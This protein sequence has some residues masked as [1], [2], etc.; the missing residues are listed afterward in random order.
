MK[1]LLFDIENSPIVTWSWGIHADPSH[2][3]K[4]VKENWYVMCWSAKWLNS[5]EVIS[6]AL[7]D[8]QY[9]HKKPC[10][11][12][13][14]KDLWKLLDEADIVIAHNGKRFDCKKSNARFMMHGMTPPSPYKVID[15]LTVSRSMFMFT[16]NRL[17]DLGQYLGVG[18][19]IDTGGFDLWKEC[20]E[21]NLKSWDKMIKYCKQDVILLEKVY[22]KI[23]PYIKNHP[24]L[25]LDNGNCPKC[26]SSKLQKRGTIMTKRAMLRRFCCTACGGWCSK[27]IEKYDKKKRYT[28]E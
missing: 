15:T 7:P 9:N 22:L 1:I 17:G 28:N 4:F 12:R 27:K 19:K 13:I 14:L 6:K 8:Y 26:G 5:K 21:G 2:S 3:T 18:S 10:D 11:K 16:S 23:R 20:M 24:H 25:S